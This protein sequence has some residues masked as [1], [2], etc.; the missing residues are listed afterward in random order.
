MDQNFHFCRCRPIIFFKMASFRLLPVW[1]TNMDDLEVTTTEVLP[2]PR[3]WTIGN[4]GVIIGARQPSLAEILSQIDAY[5]WLYNDDYGR[6]PS[7]IIYKCRWYV[8]FD[9]VATVYQWPIV[10]FHPLV[11]ATLGVSVITKQPL[12]DVSVPEG[13]CVSGN[14]AIRYADFITFT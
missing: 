3:S 5:L 2:L 4:V 14:K 6:R 7:Y 10:G 13:S 1:G 12:A 8:Y 11:D 9:S